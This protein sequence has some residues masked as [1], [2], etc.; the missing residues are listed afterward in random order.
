MAPI[1]WATVFKTH[2]RW[3]GLA[4]VVLAAV[5]ALALCSR[6]ADQAPQPEAQPGPDAG[7]PADPPPLGWHDFETRA[8]AVQ[9]QVPDGFRPSVQDGKPVAE[10]VAVYFQS[11]DE[12]LAG[13]SFAL[14][15]EAEAS[16][17]LPK[18][19]QLIASAKV[20]V[21]GT[22]RGLQLVSERADG[23]GGR[24]LIWQTLTQLEPK[25]HVSFGLQYPAGYAKAA[26]LEDLYRELLGRVRF[27]TTAP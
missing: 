1:P 10:S 15:R 27:G 3:L 5:L 18:Q 13:F 6:G 16:R 11:P 23:Q 20:T 12:P 21:D 14:C 17:C 26:E 19:A 7:N 25:L 8:A 9:F 22:S 24:V 4:A 2:R